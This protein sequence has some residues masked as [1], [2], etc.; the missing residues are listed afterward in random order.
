MD[1]N[2]WT[3]GA[4]TDDAYPDVPRDW[5]GD[6]PRGAKA[7]QEN[8]NQMRSGNGNG[9]H[10][11]LGVGGSAPM[12]VPGYDTRRRPTRGPNIDTFTYE[13]DWDDD[14]KVGGTSLPSILGCCC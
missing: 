1:L 10:T 5:K 3:T 7:I 6:L 14:C 9:T 8:A 4:L 11:N 12:H 2:D 13:L